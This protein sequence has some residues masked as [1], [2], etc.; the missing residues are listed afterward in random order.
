MIYLKQGVFR[1]SINTVNYT[2]NANEGTVKV[3]LSSEFQTSSLLADGGADWKH[4]EQRL[5]MFC[6]LNRKH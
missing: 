6:L 5:Q 1:E 2:E 4:Q 3:T